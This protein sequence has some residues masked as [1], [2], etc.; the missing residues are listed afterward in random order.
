[1]ARTGSPEYLQECWATR[2]TS[3]AWPRSCAPTRPSS[4]PARRSRSTAAPRTDSSSDGYPVGMSST[5]GWYTAAHSE[6]ANETTGARTGHAPRRH[7]KRSKCEVETQSL[8]EGGVDAIL[9]VRRAQLAGRTGSVSGAGPH[10]GL[11]D[12]HAV[13]VE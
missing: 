5:A 8:V 9:G 6:A 7:G 1:M 4:S 2:L 13:V 11:V 10:D 12:H 3:G